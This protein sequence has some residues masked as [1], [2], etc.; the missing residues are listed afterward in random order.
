M[1]V[2]PAKYLT[3]ASVCF[4]EMGGHRDSVASPFKYRGVDIPNYEIP[5]GRNKHF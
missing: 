2:N 3:L 4:Q 1:E 5:A